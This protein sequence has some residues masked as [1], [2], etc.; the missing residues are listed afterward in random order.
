MPG[1]DIITIESVTFVVGRRR[2]PGTPIWYDVRLATADETT[3]PATTL[4]SGLCEL[5]EL[6][7]E[8]SKSSVLCLEASSVYGADLYTDVKKEPDEWIAVLE[9]RNMLN[10]MPKDLLQRLRQRTTTDDGLVELNEDELYIV[11][12]A[13]DMELM[14][15]VYEPMGFEI[16][17]V[18][19]GFMTSRIGDLIARC[20]SQR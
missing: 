13:A 16:Q 2:Y 10:R 15:N 3:P 5:C 6:I 12:E 11:Q 14:Q 7:P 19:D 1:D 18:K 17:S 4:C 9:E 20:S 8:L